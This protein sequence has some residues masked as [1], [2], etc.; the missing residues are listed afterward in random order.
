MTVEAAVT[1]RARYEA[2]A[3]RHQSLL[4]VGID[5]DPARLPEGAQMR[6]F[7]FGVVEATADIACCFKPNIAFFEP[8]QGDGLALLKELIE[9]IPHEVPVLLDAKRGDIGHTAEAYA[10]AVFDVL[11][12]DAVTLNPYLGRDSLDPFL[13]RVDRH[14]FLLCRTSNEGARD[15]Q[16]LPVGE[17]G[18]PLYLEVARLAHQWNEHGNIGLVVGATYPDDARRIRDVCPDE[19]FLMPGVGAQQGEIDAAVSAAVDASGGGILVNASRAVLYPPSEA[20]RWADASRE[21]AIGLRDAINAAR[22]R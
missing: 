7:L 18:E 17:R 10:R 16:D 5:P 11:G 19:L 22:G 15:L 3:D 4:C 12:A 8:D 9:V 21:A 20:G 2:A 13:K 6:E 14:S 1:F